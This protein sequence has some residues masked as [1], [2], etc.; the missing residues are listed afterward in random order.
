MDGTLDASTPLIHRMPAA[1]TPA[2][3]ASAKIQ[4][5]TTPNQH[6]TSASTASI[7]FSLAMTTR[8]ISPL[9]WVFN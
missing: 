3:T 7:G 6:S 5:E 8:S 4:Y 1:T 9:N 2:A